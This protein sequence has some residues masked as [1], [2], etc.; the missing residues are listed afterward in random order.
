MTAAH[1]RYLLEEVQDYKCSITGLELL[2]GNTCIALKI[3]RSRRG[4]P[5]P[6]N[7]QL[8]HESIVQLARELP[9]NEVI[10]VCKIVVTNN[11]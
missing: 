11:R 4:K 8:V 6:E 10:E 2:P 9:L 5:G 1:F 3:P 7:I